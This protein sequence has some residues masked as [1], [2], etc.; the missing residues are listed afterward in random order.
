MDKQQKLEI[1]EKFKRSE[2][3]CGSVEVQ[4]AVMTSRILELTEHMKANH[5]DFS[6]RRG[7]LALVNRRRNL[8]DYLK[9]KDF[10]R[11]TALI[12]ALD[13]RR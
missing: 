9:D 7:L 1:I 3:D 8:L 4:V 2:N 11:Y 12:R 10:A 13:L 6:T 5:K